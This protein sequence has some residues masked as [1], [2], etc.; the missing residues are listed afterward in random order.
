VDD[1]GAHENHLQLIKS[2]MVEDPQI[3]QAAEAFF[4]AKTRDL[5][6][7]NKY[8]LSGNEGLC[9]DI[10]VRK[11]QFI[12]YVSKITSCVHIGRC[13]ELG[14]HLLCFCNGRK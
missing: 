4:Y 3:L 10:V 2:A 12:L 8:T 1:S 11:D 5:I 6:K 13:F 14:P 9:I 7:E